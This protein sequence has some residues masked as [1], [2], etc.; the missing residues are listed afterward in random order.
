VLTSGL[1]F[2]TVEPSLFGL[3]PKKPD[4]SMMKRKSNWD[5]VSHFFAIYFNKVNVKAGKLKSL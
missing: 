3:S 2:A 1:H 4:E 5:L